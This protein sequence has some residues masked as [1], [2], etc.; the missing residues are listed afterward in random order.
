MIDRLLMVIRLVCFETLFGRE[1]RE[2]VNQLIEEV[3]AN[4]E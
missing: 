4:Y 1:R 2:Q 3:N